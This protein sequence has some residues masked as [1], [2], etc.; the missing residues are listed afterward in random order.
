MAT[1]DL[2]VV[3]S[4]V[5][6]VPVLTHEGYSGRAAQTLGR[7]ATRRSANEETQ[8]DSQADRPLHRIREVRLEQGVSLRTAAR[9]LGTDIRT[10][11]AQEH[12]QSDLTLSQFFAWQAVLEVPIEDLLAEPGIPLSRP[13][14][15]RARM[16]RLMKTVMSIQEMADSD[17]VSRFAQTLVEQLVEVMPELSE[18]SSWHNVGQ[19]RS[20]S[21]LGRVAE[22]PIPDSFLGGLANGV[23]VD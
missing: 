13:V 10:V 16:I 11:R 9:R 20:L 15:E 19:R 8:V 21:E 1:A 5:M 7:R 2:R 18:V 23:E 22:C 17:A 6:P 12:P 14:M 4:D 3:H